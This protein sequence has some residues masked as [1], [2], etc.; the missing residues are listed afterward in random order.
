M[1][2]EVLAKDIARLFSSPDWCRRIPAD[3]LVL[4]VYCGVEHILSDQRRHR[5]RLREAHGGQHTCW[6]HREFS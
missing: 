6:C 4:G 1:W 3:A 2:P 5:C